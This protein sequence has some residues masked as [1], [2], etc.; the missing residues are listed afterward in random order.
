MP[1]VDLYFLSLLLASPDSINYPFTLSLFQ[2]FLQQHSNSTSNSTATAQATAQQQHNRKF[3]YSVVEL[4]SSATQCKNHV[5][6]GCAITTQHDDD[7]KT[8]KKPIKQPNRFNSR[9]C[10]LIR[11]N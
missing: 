11:V 10:A 2:P 3:Y 6:H 4:Q 9:G 7:K 8:N 1:Y 5:A